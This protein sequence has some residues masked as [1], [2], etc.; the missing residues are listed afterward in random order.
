MSKFNWQTEEELE[1]AAS[2]IIPFLEDTDERREANIYWFKQN[3]ILRLKNHDCKKSTFL[4]SLADMLEL[5][6]KRALELYKIYEGAIFDAMHDNRRYGSAYQSIPESYYSKAKKSM[7]DQE[8]LAYE[9]G[10][11]MGINDLERYKKGDQK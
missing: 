8:W 5:N 7:V 9:E 11:K 10:Y 6:E 1:M 3:D 4:Q 2:K